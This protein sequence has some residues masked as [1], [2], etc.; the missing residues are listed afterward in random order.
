MPKWPESVNENNSFPSTSSSTNNQE[1]HSNPVQEPIE[2]T[3][4]IQ[5]TEGK[6]IF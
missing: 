1:K 4:S 6:F 2:E 3:L 5:N